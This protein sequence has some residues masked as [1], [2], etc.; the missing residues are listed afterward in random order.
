MFVTDPAAGKV[1][2]VHGA[3]HVAA[4]LTLF[5]A[6]WPTAISCFARRFSHR[7]LFAVLSWAAVV[8]IPVL[9]VATWVDAGIFGLLERIMLGAGFAW[10]TALAV[11]LHRDRDR[12][13]TP[14]RLAKP[15]TS[16][17]A[18]PSR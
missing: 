1:S 12:T 2:T 16:S 14:M 18:Q 7:R 13:T 15:D 10:L 8:V 9:F 17:T 5:F 11:R 3:L 6:A 4:A